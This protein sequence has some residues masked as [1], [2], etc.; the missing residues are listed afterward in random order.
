M[1]VLLDEIIISKS[2]HAAWTPKPKVSKSK[3]RTNIHKT[4]T[5]INSVQA[6]KIRF[7]VKLNYAAHNTRP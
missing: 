1:I 5:K 4:N 6:V 2:G 7:V 3:F